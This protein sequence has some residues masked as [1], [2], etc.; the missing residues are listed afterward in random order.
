MKALERPISTKKCVGIAD[1]FDH[2]VGQAS[3]LGG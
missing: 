3:C 2:T 1:H